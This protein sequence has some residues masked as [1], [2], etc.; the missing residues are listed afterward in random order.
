MGVLSWWGRRSPPAGHPSPFTSFFFF[1]SFGWIARAGWAR[2]GR[3]GLV[4]RECGRCSRR[5]TTPILP[6]ERV[7]SEV[8]WHGSLATGPIMASAE[9]AR[10]EG[11]VGPKRHRGS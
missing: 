4:N 10:G 6:R 5:Q 8:S 1:F 7:L 9:P 2:I 11:T 3:H